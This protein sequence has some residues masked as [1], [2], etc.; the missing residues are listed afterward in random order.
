MLSECIVDGFTRSTRLEEGVVDR[1]G[2]YHSLGEG[3][4]GWLK[5]WFGFETSVFC[6]FGEM[7]VILDKIEFI[8]DYE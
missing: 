4:Y 5:D 7:F 6:H 1:D 3:G 8:F 2:D